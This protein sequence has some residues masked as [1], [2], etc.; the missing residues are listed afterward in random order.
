MVGTSSLTFFDE[1]HVTA[2]IRYL[3]TCFDAHDIQRC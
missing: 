1:L 3:S 2:M